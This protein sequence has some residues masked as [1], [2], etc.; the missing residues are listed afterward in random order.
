LRDGLERERPFSGK[1]AL[2][3]PETLPERKQEINYRTN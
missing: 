3:E 1:E 2:K